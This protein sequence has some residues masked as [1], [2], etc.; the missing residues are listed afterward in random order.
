MFEHAKERRILFSSFDPD[1]CTM[2]P[3]PLVARH[4]R[5]GQKQNRYPVLFL[6]LGPTKR[7]PPYVDKRTTNTRLSVNFALAE[8]ILGLN[9]HSEELL[10]VKGHGGDRRQDTTELQRAS[11]LGLVSFCWGD[12]LNQPGVVEQLK[13][14]TSINGLIYDRIGELATRSSVFVV[15]KE[16]KSALFGASPAPSRRASDDLQTATVSDAGE[17]GLR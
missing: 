13:K 15:E 14:T 12:D 7:Y 3:F 4:C 2:S 16:T 11:S 8:Q 17:E 9:F 10:Q 6:I 1:I 5:I